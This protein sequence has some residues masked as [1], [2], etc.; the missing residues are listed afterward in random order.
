MTRVLIALAAAAMA[1][2]LACG[3]APERPPPPTPKPGAGGPGAAGAAQAAAA[4]ATRFSVLKPYYVQHL[5]RPLDGKVNMFRSNLAQFAP[6]VE[7][8][9]DTEVAS[10]EPKTPLEYYDVNSY[11]LT[12]IMS[13]TA[14]SKSLLID[15]RGKSYVVEVGT[16]VGSHGGKIASITATELRI[17]EPGR[18]P[19]IMALE[20]PTQ[21]LENTMRTFEEY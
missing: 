7:I 9:T 8:E 15:P 12:L 10:D 20:P 19:T 4:P 13:G 14:V 18:P 1:V 21:D 11:R 3:S 5:K 6:R 16:R 17:E 2:V